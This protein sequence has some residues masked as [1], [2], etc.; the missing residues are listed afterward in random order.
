MSLGPHLNP[1]EILVLVH[2]DPTHSLQLEYVNLLKGRW[3]T[4]HPVEGTLTERSLVALYIGAK[5]VRRTV[6]QGES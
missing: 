6:Q 4:E 5:V 2:I 3:L 1:G